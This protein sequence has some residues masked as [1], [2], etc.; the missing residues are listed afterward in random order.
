M[1]TIILI[2]SAIG[3]FSQGIIVNPIT[4]Q[5]D[6]VGITTI[7]PGTGDVVGPA[8]STDNAIVLYNGITG[9]LIKDSATLLPTGNLVGTGQANT[10][11]TGAQDFSAATSFLIKT[12]AG[13]A[14]TSLS[15]IGLNST[16]LRLVY[17][18]GSTTV[19]V[20]TQGSSST[21]GNCAQYDSNGAVTAVSAPCA[22]DST[23]QTGSITYCASA[24]GN[25]SYACN[26][27]P[28]FTAYDTD[29]TCVTGEICT[30]TV[31]Q[32][33]ADVQNTGTASF[34]PN[35]LTAKTIKKGGKNQNLT[36]GDVEAGQVVTL[37]YNRTAD[38]WQYQ[39]QLST[40]VTNPAARVFGASFISSDGSTALTS[41]TTAYF[42]FPFTCTITAWNVTVNAG[43]ATID[44][45][46]IAS[47]T[48]IPTVSNTITASAT[49]AISTGTSIHSTTL[50]GWTTS[51]AA[52]D[53]FGINLKTVATATQ[54]NLTVECQ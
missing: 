49:P 33:Y 19:T 39:S 17:G 23:V 40:V 31:I 32:F 44:I 21:S 3:L 18:N 50:T 34:A 38:I 42:V 46:K 30:G 12:A 15:S 5:P 20:A 43:T 48:A 25:D 2:L 4:K 28:A 54:A 41:G 29:G 13:F 22:T 37:A 6:F 51:V 14:P 24:T 26:F 47:G 53:V 7:P 1:K 8:S 45:W 35:G 11:S 52:N 10:Y 36:T 16:N 9:K 27:S